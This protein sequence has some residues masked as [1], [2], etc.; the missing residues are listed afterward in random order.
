M[1]ALI[2]KQK[3]RARNLGNPNVIAFS[4]SENHLE[5]PSYEDFKKVETMIGELLKP[6]SA[7]LPHTVE[8]DGQLRCKLTKEVSSSE[9]TTKLTSSAPKHSSHPLGTQPPP[10]DT[11]KTRTK[12]A[13]SKKLGELPQPAKF[14]IH[15]TKPKGAQ[16]SQPEKKKDAEP[17]KAEKRKRESEVEAAQKKTKTTDPVASEGMD[18]PIFYF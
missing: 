4:D 1:E 12:Q 9:A 3:A 15:K 6:S 17:S 7:N 5:L 14:L 2:F 11:P 10:S 13:P 16:P 18:P 8:M